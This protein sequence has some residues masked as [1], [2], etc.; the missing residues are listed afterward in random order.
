MKLLSALLLILC[1]QYGFGATYYISTNG[2]DRT[3]NGSLH[4]PWQTLYRA[5]STVVTAGD[6]IH[7]TAGTFIERVRC[8][9]ATGVSIEGEGPLSVIQSTLTEQ[10]VAIIIAVSP[11]GTNGNQHISN[12]TLDGNKRTTSWAIEIRG[13]SNFSIHDCT[14]KDFDDRGILWTG[15]SDNDTAPPNLYATGNTFYNNVVINCAKYEGYGRGCINIGGQKEMLIYNN[16][17]TQTGRV[18][19]TNGWPVKCFN[20]GFLKGC[21]IYNNKIIKQAYDGVTWDFAIELFNESG[22]EIYNNTIVGSVDMNHQTKGEYAYS[23][24]IH[25]NIIGPDTPQKGIE[26]GLTME[27]ETETA[28]IEN[29]QLRNLAIPF[30]FTPRDGSMI[31]DVTIR[32]NTCENIGV[33]DGSHRGYAINFSSDGTGNHIINNFFISGN[34]FIANIKAAPFYGIELTGVA[35]TTNVKIQNNTIAN[36]NVACIAANPAFVIDTL[37]IENNILSGNGNN[38]DP[39]Y[40][41]GTPG[42]YIFEKN[43]KINSAA[44]PGFNFSQQLIRPLYHEVKNIS[45]LEYIALLAFFVA[46]GFGSREKIYVF[47][48]GLIY[49]VIYTLIRFEQ[50][51]PGNAVINIC[52]AVF[53]I[54]G[55]I[56]WSKRDRK[57]HRIVRITSSSKKEWFIQFGFFLLSFAVGLFAIN[58]YKKLFSRDI[59]LFGDAAAGAAAFTAI[60]SMTN[61]KVES[62]YWWMTAAA[63]LIPLYFLKHYL[64]DGFYYFMLFLMACWG[65]YQWKRRRMSKRRSN[66]QNHHKI[67]AV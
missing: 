16:T 19:G 51:L 14:I 21:K 29:N 9:L 60:W 39:L 34:K 28:I 23:V 25:D 47:P 1:F 38:N 41:R 11:E 17:I 20:N 10:F 31:S 62:W 48:A 50:G 37:V 66:N 3:G 65:L 63:V 5:T 36:F 61:K 4:N 40:V 15:R 59:I 26:T 33:T 24:Y 45:L 57:K 64:F 30:Y 22:L 56:R 54:Y 27:Y 49:T 55:W 13:R 32:N 42:N 2:N 7:L 46:L 6:I 53:C 12:I 52:F 35:S 8:T 18:K 44:S 58:Y 43:T 67:A